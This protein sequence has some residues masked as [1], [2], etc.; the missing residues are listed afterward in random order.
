MLRWS[1][2][3]GLKEASWGYSTNLGSRLE[4]AGHFR[5]IQEGGA[6]L[7]DRPETW[8]ARASDQAVGREGQDADEHADHAHQ[9]AHDDVVEPRALLRDVIEDLCHDALSA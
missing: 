6:L 4:L 7:P 1:P 8:G 9:S 3:R 2:G 5:Q